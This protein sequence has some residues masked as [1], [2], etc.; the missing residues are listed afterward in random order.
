MHS[1]RALIA[2]PSSE[3]EFQTLLPVYFAV[4]TC[5]ECT[6]YKSFG[7]RPKRSLG[8]VAYRERN[9]ANKL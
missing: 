3:G 6:D 1:P 5:I 4:C 2:Q 9:L 7:N 8:M